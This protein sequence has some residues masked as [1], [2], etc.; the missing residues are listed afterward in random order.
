M[1]GVALRLCVRALLLRRKSFKVHPTKVFGRPAADIDVDEFG[2]Q[3]R[4]RMEENI[5][6]DEPVSECAVDYQLMLV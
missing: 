4:H 1:I 2:L 5:E 6:L 3:Q